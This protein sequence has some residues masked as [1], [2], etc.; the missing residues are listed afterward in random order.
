VLTP[1]SQAVFR[2]NR[3]PYLFETECSTVNTMRGQCSDGHGS[4]LRIA[5]IAPLDNFLPEIPIGFGMS[6][7]RNLTRYRKQVHSRRWRLQAQNK[8]CRSVLTERHF[9]KVLQLSYCFKN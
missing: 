7:A 1:F 3:V 9:A 2:E 5:T 4:N 8:K 6:L